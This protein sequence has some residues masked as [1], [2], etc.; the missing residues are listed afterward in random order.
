MKPSGYINQPG[1]NNRTLGGPVSEGKSAGEPRP[2]RR[3]MGRFPP[4]GLTSGGGYY[5]G[6]R[7]GAKIEGMPRRVSVRSS[8][9]GGSPV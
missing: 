5:Y 4:M 1:R 9:S 3:D 2:I 6:L 7:A 8:G